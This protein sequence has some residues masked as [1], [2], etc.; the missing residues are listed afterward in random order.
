MQRFLEASPRTMSSASARQDGAPQQPQS[1]PGN[2]P[3]S[4]STCRAMAMLSARLEPRRNTGSYRT[5]ASQL[6]SAGASRGGEVG[7]AGSRSRSCRS[8]A[9]AA[10]GSSTLST[11][12]THPPLQASSSMNSRPVNRSSSSP[13]STRMTF[14]M[15]SAAR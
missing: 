9:R 3:A 8:L 10:K 7:T 13:S 5:G 15:P 11:P 14:S 6:R 2:S 4:W 12:P 1:S